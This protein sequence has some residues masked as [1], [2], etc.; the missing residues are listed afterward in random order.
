MTN[1]EWKELI[2]KEF[3]VSKSLANEMLHAMYETKNIKERLL[4]YL[5]RNRK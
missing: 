2:A 3:G 1:R 4:S 5:E